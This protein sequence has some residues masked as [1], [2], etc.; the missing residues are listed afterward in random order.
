[1]E[2]IHKTIERNEKYLDQ[3]IS[4]IEKLN[5]LKKIRTEEKA[6]KREAQAKALNE[7]K[8]FK[9]DKERLIKQL[10]GTSSKKKKVKDLSLN[11]SD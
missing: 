7:L 9:R 4:D 6:K 2:E 5:V 8:E 1:M 10:V 3:R 11:T